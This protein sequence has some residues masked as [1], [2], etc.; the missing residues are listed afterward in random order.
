MA[1]EDKELDDLLAEKNNITKKNDQII[2]F[3]KTDVADKNENEKPLANVKN[4][5][6]QGVDAAVMHQLKN[7]EDVQK[8]FL[9]TG[10]KVVNTNLSAIENEAEAGE[11]EAILKNNKDACDLYGIDEKTVPKWVVACAKK[12]QDFWYAVWLI[13]GFFTTVPIVFLGKK[14]KVV[15][16]KT[17]VAM[18]LA[19]IIYV[20]SVTAPLWSQWFN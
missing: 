18:L 9:Q 8:R 15:I 4:V 3:N 17:W 11:K 7:S 5:V 10:E 20:A 19:I 16:K 2:D 12:V 13:V 6:Q 14:I 1:I